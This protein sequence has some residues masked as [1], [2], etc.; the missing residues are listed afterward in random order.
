MY[1]LVIIG[2]GVTG[3]C[4]AREISKYEVNAC[5]IEKGDDVASGT[6]KANTGVIHPGLPDGKV[7]RRR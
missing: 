2:A 4:I 1:D 5:V 7:M 3:C 6:S